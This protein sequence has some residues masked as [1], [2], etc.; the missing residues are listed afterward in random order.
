MTEQV[1]HEIRANQNKA[2]D[3]F[4]YTEL[5]IHSVGREIRVYNTQSGKE[6]KRPHINNQCVILQATP[7]SPQAKLPFC[8]TAF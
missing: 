4:V 3:A 7:L 2:H 1:K 8:L 5:I 6:Q